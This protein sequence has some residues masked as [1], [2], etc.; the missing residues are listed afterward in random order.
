MSEGA[1]TRGEALSRVATYVLMFTAGTWVILTPPR[2][3]EGIIGTTSTF[4]WGALLLLASVAAV[5]ALLMKWR[6]EL[7]VL[8]LLIAGVGIYAAAVWADVPETIT[9]GPQACILTA[10]AVGLGT[11]LL[12]LRAL[13]KKHAAQHR[14]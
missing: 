5:A 8:P 3:I 9:R 13:A 6:V 10:F 7:T 12:S 11:R 2:T 1:P 14:R 4:V